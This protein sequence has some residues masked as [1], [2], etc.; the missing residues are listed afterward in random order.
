MVTV[1]YTIIKKNVEL[2]KRDIRCI[3]DRAWQPFNPDRYLALEYLEIY[4]DFHTMLC[5]INNYIY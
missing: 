3:E 1:H 4:V 5:T 2:K